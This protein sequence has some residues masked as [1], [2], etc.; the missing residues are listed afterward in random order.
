[1]AARVDLKADRKAGVL[2][3]LAS[4]LEPGHDA[5]AVATALAAELRRAADWQG[6]P[7]VVIE[8]RGDLAKV[9]STVRL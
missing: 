2:R 3:V 5:I 7:D 8:R 4:W 1:M 6:L 9:L